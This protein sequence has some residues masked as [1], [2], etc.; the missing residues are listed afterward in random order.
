MT[1]SPFRLSLLAMSALATLLFQGC[2]RFAPFEGYA[3]DCECGTMTWDGRELGMRM[4]EAEPLNADSTL[5][6]YH[7]IADLRD[8]EELE[9]RAEPRDIVLTVTAAFGGTPATLAFDEGDAGF[10]LKEVD[11]PAGSV[12]WTMGGANLDLSADGAGHTMVLNSL[13]ATRGQQQLE[14]SGLFTFDLAD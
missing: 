1:M 8:A 12:N 5:W 11:S 3:Y 10:T 2:T 14:V 7:V 4:A 6:R 13:V 9:A